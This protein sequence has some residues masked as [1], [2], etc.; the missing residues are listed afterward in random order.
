MMAW[1]LLAVSLLK[2]AQ[3]LTED[4]LLV[5]EVGNSWEAL[6]VSMPNVPFYWP[7]FENGGHGIF[8][9]TKQQLLEI[10]KAA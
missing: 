2:A 10:N 7:E 8:M 9:L 5:V 1:I 3:H 4:G 6:E